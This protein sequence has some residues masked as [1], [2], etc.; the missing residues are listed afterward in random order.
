MKGKQRLR[1]TTKTAKIKKAAHRHRVNVLTS[2][3]IFLFLLF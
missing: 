2:N 1:R 3:I